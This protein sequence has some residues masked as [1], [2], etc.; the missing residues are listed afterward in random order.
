MQGMAS[1]AIR[2][3]ERIFQ[4]PPGGDPHSP[5]QAAQPRCLLLC[6]PTTHRPSPGFFELIAGAGCCR[7]ANA[8]GGG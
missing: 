2:T 1:T 6:N 7:P 4:L 8:G 3:W 5:V